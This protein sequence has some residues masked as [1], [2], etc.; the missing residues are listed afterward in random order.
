M[1]SISEELIEMKRKEILSSCGSR[2]ALPLIFESLKDSSWRLRKTALECLIS[3]YEPEIYIQELIHLLYLEDNA[4]AR[5]S[6]IE[7]LTRLG[8]RAIDAL[9]KAFNTENTDVRKFIIDILGSIGGHETLPLLLDALKDDDDNVRASAIE[10]LGR[11]KEPKV[12]DALIEVVKSGDTWTAYPAVLALGKIGNKKAIPCLIEALKTRTLIEPALKSLAKFSEADTLEHIIPFI[13]DRR[14]SVQEEAIKAIELFYQNGID[15]EFIV[16]GLKTQFGDTAYELILPHTKSKNPQ[17]KSAAIL[18]LGILKDRNI[19]PFLLEL[20]EDTE[21]IDMVKRALLY[22]GQSSPEMLLELLQKETPQRRR[23]ICEVIAEIKNPFFYETL[24]GLLSDMDGH[25][26]SNAVTGIGLI[27][28]ERAIEP[29]LELLGHPYPDI[30]SAVVKALSNLK[31]HIKI[32][33]L[34]DIVNNENPLTRKNAILILGELLKICN[35]EN[36][37]KILEHLEFSLKDPDEDVR[38]A[39]VKALSNLDNKKEFYD[40]LKRILF[41]ALTDESAEVRI[42]TIETLGKYPDT[43]ILNSLILMANDVNHNVRAKLARVLSNYKEEKSLH[44]LLTLLHDPNGYVIT[45]AIESLSS[46]REE[47]ARDNIL[48]MLNHSD[49]EILRTAILSLSNFP[50]TLETIKPFLYNK[51]WATRLATVQTLA[52][53]NSAEALSLLEEAYDKEE[54]PS[55]RKAI[56]VA[57]GVK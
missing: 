42:Q 5:N 3:S 53:F 10:Y 13:D 44:C 2:E 23:I 30:Q 48:K 46:F 28:D 41:M 50:E 18:I 39:V 40:E 51:D 34:L 7:G 49:R 6:A 27:G 9:I 15:E 19:L 55:V 4:G 1:K 36:M 20:S 57:I 38:K 32:D 16:K 35:K 29:L 25:V 22:I 54:D 11:L 45:H 21:L 33:R 43:E 17:V 52:S 56:E 31:E 12:V 26:I 47:T 14:R 8:K 24:L 37:I